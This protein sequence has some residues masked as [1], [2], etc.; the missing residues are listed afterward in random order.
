MFYH[1]KKIKINSS[2]GEYT[3]SINQKE[4]KRS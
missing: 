3:V 1:D 2:V 4:K